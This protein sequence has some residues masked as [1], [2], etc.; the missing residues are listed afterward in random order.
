MLSVA[1]APHADNVLQ[2]M[3][4][5]LFELSAALANTDALKVTTGDGDN[6]DP[7]TATTTAMAEKW[8]L[9]QGQ[10]GAQEH[11]IPGKY[12]RVKEKLVNDKHVWC[13]RGSSGKQR[14]F[15]YCAGHGTETGNQYTH[16]A[17]NFKNTA[18]IDQLQMSGDPRWHDTHIEVGRNQMVYTRIGEK[19]TE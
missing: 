4:Q 14:R 17:H 9:V 19:H 7:D 5:E 6:E 11:K 1:R 18:Q 12:D 10:K 16:A 2:R 8:L 13:K 15:L 3:I